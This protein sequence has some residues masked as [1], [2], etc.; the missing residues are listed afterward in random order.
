MAHYREGA[1]QRVKADHQDA[2][3]L[4]RYLHREA[5]ELRLWEPLKQGP[6][7][8]WR[9][10]KRR[11][12]LVQTVTRMQQSLTD[13]GS[14]QNDVDRLIE[15]CQKN[16]QEDRSSAARASQV[17]WLG[18]TSASLSGD[19]RGWPADRPGDSGQQRT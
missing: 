18:D 10:P 19:P 7:R 8:F 1:G 3:L 17:A 11:A 2:Q 16:H 5:V 4:A 13:L 12:T 9:L 14:L 15:Q 6:Q